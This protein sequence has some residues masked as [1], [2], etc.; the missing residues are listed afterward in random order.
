MIPKKINEV[1]NLRD[2]DNE[3]MS[4]FPFG[5]K[6]KRFS[7]FSQSDKLCAGIFDILC[8]RENIHTLV[9]SVFIWEFPNIGRDF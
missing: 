7:Q 4:R 5:S 6:M 8:F 1:H 2:T 3:T 9:Y